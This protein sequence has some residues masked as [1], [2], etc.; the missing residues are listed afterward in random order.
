MVKDPSW[1]IEKHISKRALP[2]EEILSWL[3]WK[4]LDFDRIII[5][6]EADVIF[7]RFLNVDE[8]IFDQHDLINGIAVVDKQMLHMDGFVG[9]GCFYDPIPDN[10]REL[11]FVVNFEKDEKIIST[12]ELKTKIIR[13]ILVVESQLA[14]SIIVEQNNPVIPALSFRLVSK[15]TGRVV[16]FSPF[17]DFT[18]KGMKIT[19]EEK[20]EKDTNT[21]PLFV[22]SS[23]R[24]ISKIIVNGQ[25]YGMITL[26]FEYLDSIGNKYESELVQIPINIKQ[27]EKLEVPISSELEGQQALLLEPKVI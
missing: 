19:I 11:S 20:V 27:K 8:K 6:S 16:N 13:P 10:E 18:A 14:Q 23:E 24:R 7:R 17:M 12:V 21:A 2:K 5:K 25:G 3:K 15:G 4:E 22:Y 26:G 1:L 9:F